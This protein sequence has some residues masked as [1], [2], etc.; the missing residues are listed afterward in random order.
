MIIVYEKIVF[1]WDCPKCTFHHEWEE[2]EDRAIG[3]ELECEK[4]G[5]VVEKDTWKLED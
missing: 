3:D 1:C 4:C 5:H 2:R